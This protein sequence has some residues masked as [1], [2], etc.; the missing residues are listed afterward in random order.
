MDNTVPKWHLTHGKDAGL[1]RVFRDMNRL[2]CLATFKKAAFLQG[3]AEN[4]A[5]FYRGGHY[6]EINK[7]DRTFA[8][9]SN[10]LNIMF[11]GE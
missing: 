4:A 6:E 11:R 10:M 3:A 8:C 1:F 9:Y 7:N 5:L 2:K